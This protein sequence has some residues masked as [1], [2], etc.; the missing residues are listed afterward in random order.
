MIILKKRFGKKHLPNEYMLCVS[1]KLKYPENIQKERKL[2]IHIFL[3][4]KQIVQLR[5]SVIFSVAELNAAEL[6]IDNIISASTYAII[7]TK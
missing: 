6:L 4:R 7:C 1:C 3:K 2:Q 5:N